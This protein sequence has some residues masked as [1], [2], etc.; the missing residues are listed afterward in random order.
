MADRIFLEN[1]PV[2][3]ARVEGSSNVYEA[4]NFILT[5]P[6]W[7]ADEQVSTC[8]ICKNKFNQIRRKHHCRQCGNVRCNKCCSEK[9]PLPQ[10]GIN[11]PERVCDVCRP[12]TEL[13]TK[14]RSPMSSFQNEAAIGLAELCRDPNKI[15]F[16]VELGGI[17]TLIAL[18][19]QAADQEATVSKVL[20][21]LH[22]LSTHQPLHQLMADAGAIRAICDIM[23]RADPSK[24]DLLQDGIGSLMIFCKS[25]S[26][27]QQVISDQALPVILKLFRNPNDAIALLAIST[28][29][30]M[31]EH[32]GTHKAIMEGNVNVLPKVLAQTTSFDEQMQE[33]SLKVLGHL[34]MGPAFQKHRIIQEDFSTG[35]CLL[36][37]LHSKPSNIQILTNAACV[38]ANVATNQD[39][40]GCLQSLMESMCNL[41]QNE[42]TNI[43]LLVHVT[44]GIANFSSFKQNAHK[45]VSCLPLIVWKCLKS[46]NPG[47]RTHG[48]RAVLNLLKH[49]PSQT[50]DQLISDGASLVLKQIGETTVLMDSIQTTLLT[51]VPHIAKP[52]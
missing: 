52:L 43:D 46:S 47:V 48:L 41:L 21:G 1:G 3:P 30:L 37:A 7:I 11:T 28:L 6:K 13:V 32:P 9:I 42:I 27:R 40:Q 29:S 39:D 22:I 12:V 44:R 35:Q 23:D 25:P 5:K 50:T 15:K 34:S 24:A 31:I 14:S 36:K 17:F 26:L 20:N 51:L 16:V 4:P 49:L 10:M 8:G 2:Y 19:R 38:I 33:V 18:A 45:L